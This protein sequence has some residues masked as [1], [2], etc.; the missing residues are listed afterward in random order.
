MI[1]GL[2]VLGWGV[3][4]IEAEAAMLGQAVSMLVPQVVGYKLT[5]K[6]REG[7][8][9]TDL[10]LTVTQA[11]RKL[12]VDEHDLD[13]VKAVRTAIGGDARILCDAN[14][15]LDLPTALWLGR[16]LADLDIHWLEEPLLS[17]DIEGYQRLRTALPMA[18]A[19]G[20]HVHARR[21][22]IPHIRAGAAD[23][24]QPDMCLVGGITETMRIGRIA[25]SFGLALAPHFMTPLH[26]HITAALPR[27]T[28]LEY[29]PFMDHLLT[30][31][32]TVK[33]GMLLI[34]DAPGHGVT[35]TEEAWERYR[36]A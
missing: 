11:L 34:P 33:D 24:L 29:Y 19:M 15:R 2:G 3:G 8:T 22:F 1:N 16:K 23:V 5:G 32:L 31:T 12:G 25:D 13:R 4:G 27:A 26:V 17:Q 30:G 9:A 6:L 10:V 20:E 14:E 18:I 7:A 35:F 21:D 28:Y 36:V